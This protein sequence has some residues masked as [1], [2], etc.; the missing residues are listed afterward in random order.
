MIMIYGVRNMLDEKGQNSVHGGCARR[1]V[2][3]ST[4]AVYGTPRNLPCRE[5]ELKAPRTAYERIRWRA[6]Q[7]RPPAHCRQ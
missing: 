5:G 7:A 2:H 6:E 1:L 4:V 3:V